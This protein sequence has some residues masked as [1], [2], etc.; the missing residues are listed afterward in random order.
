MKRSLSFFVAAVLL[1]TVSCAVPAG[2]TPSGDDPALGE[3][4]QALKDTPPEGRNGKNPACFWSPKTLASY[5]KLALHALVSGGTIPTLDAPDG[6]YTEVVQN[7][8]ECA[9]PKGQTVLDQN[10]KEFGGWWGI[11]PGWLNAPLDPGDARY[12]SACMTE[13]LNGMGE[14]IEI[15]LE[16]I[17]PVLNIDATLQ[18]EMPYEESTTYGDIF[19]A[20]PDTTPTISVCWSRYLADFCQDYGCT[21]ESWLDL[22]MCDEKGKCGLKV[23]GECGVECT[24]GGP[25]NAYYLCPKPGGGTDDH[26]VHV[27]LEFPY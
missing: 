22:R 2:E 20:P 16:G 7:V 23:I 26:T 17:T 18:A 19:F 11:A 13:R 8:I 1:S 27:R 24:K 4:R 10:G 15:L 25:G 5:Q 3:A 21:P 12:V 14:E 9:L 6:C